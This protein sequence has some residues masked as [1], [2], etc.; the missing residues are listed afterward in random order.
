[1]NQHIALDSIDT[2]EKK[3]LNIRFRKFLLF[4]SCPIIDE[5]TVQALPSKSPK[6]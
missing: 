2:T 1:L 5:A 3:E 4:T 6:P